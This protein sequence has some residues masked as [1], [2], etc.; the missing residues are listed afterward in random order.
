MPRVSFVRDNNPY[1]SRALIFGDGAGTEEFTD[2]VTDALAKRR[3]SSGRVP[4]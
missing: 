1:F 3:P 2:V 4:D